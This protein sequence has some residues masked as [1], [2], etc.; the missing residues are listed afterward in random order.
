MMSPRKTGV[1]FDTHQVYLFISP[2]PV[3][4]LPSRGSWRTLGRC[5]CRLTISTVLTVLWACFFFL[6]IYHTCLKSVSFNRMLGFFMFSFIVIFSCIF[7]MRLFFSC[8]RN[9][10]LVLGEVERRHGCSLS[11]PPHTLLNLLDVEGLPYPLRSVASSFPFSF[12]LQI[13]TEVCHT[14]IEDI[15]FIWS[16]SPATGGRD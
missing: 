2:R 15:A 13:L 14:L 1:G 16:T 9:W 4:F 5:Q 11:P 6:F 10:G 3:G 12:P 8:C 7:W